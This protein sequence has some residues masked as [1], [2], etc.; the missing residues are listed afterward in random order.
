MRPTIP[1]RGRKIPRRGPV[2]PPRSAAA[3][4]YRA[5]KVSPFHKVMR[6]VEVNWLL[7][8]AELCNRASLSMAQFGVNVESFAREMRKYV[9]L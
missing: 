5:V 7:G 1:P 2:R 6:R 4:Q 9:R 8:F 3:M